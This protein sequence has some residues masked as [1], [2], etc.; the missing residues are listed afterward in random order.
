LEV[1]MIALFWIFFIM[2]MILA[3]YVSRLK[4]RHE[5]RLEALERK[6]LEKRDDVHT[7][8]ARTAIWRGSLPPELRCLDEF[9]A[10]DYASSRSRPR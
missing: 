8:S 3:G 5:E 4:D 6:I 2:I 9:D 1:E 10:R 7:P